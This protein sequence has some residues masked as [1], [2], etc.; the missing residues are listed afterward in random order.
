MFVQKLMH[1]DGLTS[2]VD[3]PKARLAI[4]ESSLISQA[5][6]LEESSGMQLEVIL[7]T[8]GSEDESTPYSSFTLEDAN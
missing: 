7:K 8:K 1:L 6:A 2:E 3:S 4:Q 5:K